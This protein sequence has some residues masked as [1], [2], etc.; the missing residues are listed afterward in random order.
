MG[1]TLKPGNL[2]GKDATNYAPF[3]GSMAETIET[4]LDALMRGDGLPGLNMDLSDQSVRDR[5]RLF[6]AIAR[7]VVLHL[8]ANADAFVLAATPA[9]TTAR[10]DKITVG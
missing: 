9:G 2:I 5:R 6:V 1:N 4:E 3:A 8:A 7:G 10:V